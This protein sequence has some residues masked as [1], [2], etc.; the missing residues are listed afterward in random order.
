MRRATIFAVVI[1]MPVWL[2]LHVYGQ[3]NKSMAFITINSPEVRFDS[4]LQLLTRATGK[5][6]S[7]DPRSIKPGTKIKVP[8]AKI[9]LDKWLDILRRE[10]RLNYRL[11]GEHY[12]L[13][14]DYKLAKT[15][16]RRNRQSEKSNIKKINPSISAG[17]PEKIPDTRQ[18]VTSSVRETVSSNPQALEVYSNPGASAAAII[19]VRD[20]S[21]KNNLADS[22]A[23]TKQITLPDNKS[24]IDSVGIFYNKK[25]KN[26]NKETLPVTSLSKLEIGLQGIGFAYE[27]KLGSKLTIDLSAG[28]GG[29]YILADKLQYNLSRYAPGL[30]LSA[31]PRW[32]YNGTRQSR[33]MTLDNA[34]NYFG[35]RIK[36]VHD[37]S[38]VKSEGSVILFNI[39]WGIQKKLS[40]R[41]FINTHAGPGYAMPVVPSPYAIKKVFYPAVDVKIGYLL[42]Q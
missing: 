20:G 41:L 10:L 2:S 18:T 1:L 24:N 25:N 9:P 7:Y 19:V 23:Y 26:K 39:H 36:Y 34:G 11:L 33:N 3:Q 17:L 37:L 35:A 22:G 31:N 27:A 13:T 42:N 15:T 12:I 5:R 38:K 16:V 6:F 32:Y 29:S 14:S 21:K 30:Y 40:Q 8:A 4:L 28:L